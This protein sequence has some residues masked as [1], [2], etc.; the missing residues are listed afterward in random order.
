MWH[1]HWEAS[2]GLLIPWYHSWSV[3]NSNTRLCQVEVISC[4]LLTFWVG[5]I[6]WHSEPKKWLDGSLKFGGFHMLMKIHKMKRILSPYFKWTN[7]RLC[8]LIHVKKICDIQ[9]RFCISTF[10]TSGFHP[11]RNNG[12]YIFIPWDAHHTLEKHWQV[13]VLLKKDLQTNFLIGN[14]HPGRLTWNLQI[15]HEKK[16]KWSEPNLHDDVPC[17][18]SGVDHSFVFFQYHAQNDW[19]VKMLKALSRNR[20][21]TGRFSLWWPRWKSWWMLRSTTRWE[22][23]CRCKHPRGE[24]RKFFLGKQRQ[25]QFC[26]VS[27]KDLLSKG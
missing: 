3:R 1:Q 8:H 15:T 2:G 12:R 26:R 23:K 27:N 21:W 11:H 22:E 6:D 7:Q 17:Y 14:I 24:W 10:R 18:S 13:I 19:K 20:N 9:Y 5:F 25:E 16:G 4:N